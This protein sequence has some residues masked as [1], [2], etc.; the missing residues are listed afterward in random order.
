MKNLY[1]LYIS[2]LVITLLFG[3]GTE[4]TPVYTL[5]TSVTGEGT[6][7][8]QVGE[9]EEGE[10]V[11]LTATPAEHWVFQNWSGDASGA[12]VSTTVTMDRDKNVIGNFIERLYELNVTIVGEGSVTEEVIQSKSEHTFGTLIRLTPTPST[13]WNFAGWSGDIDSAEE[14]IEVTINGET[15]ITVTFERIDYPLT[16]TIEGEGEVDQEVISSPK[17]T[18]YPFE[19][20]VRLVSKPEDGWVFFKWDGDLDGN[21][22]PETIE[23]D[24]GKDVISV[25]KSI[26]QLLAIE[27]N[28]EGT[29][30]MK[31]ESFEENPSRR[32]VTLTAVA[33]ENWNFA[34]WSGDVNSGSSSLE[35]TVDKPIS[36][37]VSF[38]QNILVTLNTFSKSNVEFY[39][40]KNTGSGRIYASTTEI[41][42]NDNEDGI[43]LSEDNGSTWAKTYDTGAVFIKGATQDPDLVIAGLV[44]GGY[45]IS[46]DGGK[47]WNSGRI[48]DPFSNSITFTDASA[49]NNQSPIYLST[50]HATRS[51]IFKSNN[52]GNSWNYIFSS[53]DAINTFGSLIEQ[54]EVVSSSPEIIY[55]RTGFA[56]D[57]I[58]SNNG[59]SSFQSIK[60][61]LPVNIT[62]I[63][64]M[65]V[66][67]DNGDQLFIS[68][69]LSNNG[70]SS[71]NQQSISANNYFW[72]N[73]FLMQ[74][75]ASSIRKSGDLGNSWQTV[76]NYEQELFG[77]SGTPAIE[78][79]FDSLFL[80]YNGVPRYKIALEL[81]KN[82]L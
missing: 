13:G 2:L 24:E 31:Q 59:G 5:T 6:V 46:Q 58:K 43:W 9:F 60:N 77:V 75:T 11:T 48:N 36:I 44:D 54:I 40:V 3:C 14:I 50:R 66:N 34:G 56:H 39:S 27:I 25:F 23:V 47:S 21:E 49:L 74:A 78:L 52:L 73:G 72:Y 64:N 68:N 67:P 19:T 37:E 42:I 35:V 22:N 76:V 15:N 79:G 55:A 81:L 26:D 45:I 28:G 41:L 8:P 63:G 61:G 82:E 29:V 51:G 33:D 1:H 53:S 17:T 4:S 7:T 30:D 65:R 38:R 18:D 32:T 57:I 10:T 80:I 71:W 12:A 70:G 69:N 62:T 20:V 16:I